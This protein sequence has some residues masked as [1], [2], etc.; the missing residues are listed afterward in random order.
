[1]TAVRLLPIVI[2]AATSLLLFKGIGLVTQGGYVLLGTTTAEAAGGGGHGG[3]G[4]KADAGGEATLVEHSLTDTTHTA[5]DQSPTLSLAPEPAAGG[6]GHGGAA[7]GDGEAPVTAEA[8]CIPADAAADSHGG[9]AAAGDHG[10][11]PGADGEHAAEAAVI[12]P[13]EPEMPLT[14]DGDAIPMMQDAEG[15]LV[16][17]SAGTGS[18]AV[19]VERLGERRADLET[20]EAEMATRLALIEA[21]EQRLNEKTALLEK[22]QTQIDGLVDQNSSSDSE[23]FKGLIATYEA[24]KPKDAANI[25]NELDLNTLLRVAKGISP[26]K[27]AP[28]MAKMNPKKAKDLTAALAMA[29]VEPTVAVTESDIASLPQIVGQ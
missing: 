5:A 22:L 17:F 13:P 10:G 1:M 9:E 7:A 26:R 29:P 12:C 16:P 4:D 8:A 25:L 27:M 23:Q 18:E 11:E 2:F 3:G 20:R 24:M 21:A 15:N 19:L 14:A 28:I 6:D